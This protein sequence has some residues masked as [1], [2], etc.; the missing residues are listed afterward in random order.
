MNTSLIN[1]DNDRKLFFDNIRY[2][3]VFLVVVYHMAASYSHY[4]AWWAVNDDNSVFFDSLI[5]LLGVF[6]MPAFFF[7]AGYFAL[8]SLHRYGTWNFLKKKIIRLGIPWLIGVLLLGPIRIYIYQFSR[9]VQEL[10]LWQLFIVNTREAG[11]FRT[12][13]IDSSLQ[14]HH[15]PFW[16][17]SLLLFFFIVLG[18]LHHR[19]FSRAERPSA[20]RQVTDP[21]IKSIFS[22]FILVS[23]VT[24][25]M[26]LFM[27]LFFTKEPGKQ[28]FVIIASILQFQPTRV[29]LYGICFIMGI[30]A[31][32]KNWFSCRVSPGNPLLWFVVALTFLLVE[33]MIFASLV[34]RFT[35][36]LGVL[37]VTSISFLVFSIIMTLMTFGGRYW[38]NGKK[39]NQLFAQNSYAIYLIHF[40]IVL[41]VQLLMYKWWDVSTYIK[42]ITG[43]ILSVLLSF[44]LSEFL[45]RPYPKSSI[46]GMVSLFGVLSLLLK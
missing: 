15:G 17:L 14:F 13:Y 10:N 4:G 5:R 42:F 12:G 9:G 40:V 11:M 30:Y 33:E 31:F 38:N 39:L 34:R 18:L 27:F 23:I 16:F 19:I 36:T 25:I 35:P 8:P 44:I 29:C 37:H 45:L 28:P 41:V 22:V 26:T 6:L 32:Y 46:L 2:F 21:S 24:T 1:E 7:I 3:L 43:S 20:D